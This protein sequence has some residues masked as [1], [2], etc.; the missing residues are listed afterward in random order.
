[1][2]QTKMQIVAALFGLLPVLSMTVLAQESA[3][4]ALRA[5]GAAYLAGMQAGFYPDLDSFAAR[6]SRRPRRD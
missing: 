6:R 3:E 4:V 5:L 2:K 1:M